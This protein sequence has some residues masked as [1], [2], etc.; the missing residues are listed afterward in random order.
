[1]IIGI[2]CDL[3]EID[4]VRHLFGRF[5]KKMLERIYTEAE[6]EAA[7][8]QKDPVPRLAKYIA[9]KEACYK[10][11]NLQKENGLS[12]QDMS[13]IYAAN[14]KPDLKLTPKAKSLMLARFKAHLSLSDTAHHAM[15]YVVLE[16]MDTTTNPRSHFEILPAGVKV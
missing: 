6:K 3:I 9:A 2:G 5:E 12:W 1:M 13:V 15:A 11:M 10:A 16:K 7:F 14:G 4:R 8:S